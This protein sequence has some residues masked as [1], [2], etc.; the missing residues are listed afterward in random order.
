MFSSVNVAQDLFQGA[1][2]SDQVYCSLRSDTADRTA[3][4]TAK[5]YAQVYELEIRNIYMR[6]NYYFELFI[7]INLILSML[8]YKLVSFC[9]I[10]P[11]CLSLCD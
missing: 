8:S 6:V 5:E 9:S 2:L 1:M 4:V 3:V 7:S 10:Y 11:Y